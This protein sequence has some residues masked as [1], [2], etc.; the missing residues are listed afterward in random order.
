MNVIAVTG[1]DTGVGKTVVAR[2]MVSW[3]RAKGVRVGVMKPI[4]TGVTA[5]DEASDAR[6]LA[7]AAESA[8]PLEVIRPYAFDLP[9]A[10]LVA[11]RA[12]GRA[13]DIARLDAALR[14]V[15]D[16]SDITVVEGAG[17]LLV[18]I[19]EK[20]DFAGL[21]LRWNADLVIVA[22][23]RLGAVNH[24]L[25][26]LRVA[27]SLSIP[28]KAIVLHDGESTAGDDATRTN[29]SLIAELAAPTPVYRLP[30]ID[31][32]MAR[33]GLIDAIERSGLMT[34]ICPVDVQA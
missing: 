20:L 9:V 2:A 11:S 24:T 27:R 29:A 34:L 6:L 19:A 25:L 3:M 33:E 7:D 14:K 21:F 23:N 16:A 32:T 22:L 18:P 1:T 5:D 31:E 10:P 12:S 28:V 8:L 15:R 13:I 4:E 30:W 26:S 17:G